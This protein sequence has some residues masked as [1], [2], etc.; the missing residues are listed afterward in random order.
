MRILPLLI[1]SKNIAQEISEIMIC[2]ITSFAFVIHVGPGY[3][4][5][6]FPFFSL[7]LFVNG[8]RKKVI[9]FFAKN[10]FI[11]RKKKWEVVVLLRV[12]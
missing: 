12:G 4:N 5:K 1:I 2:N 10:Q 6:Y 7:S 8:E 3:G 11:E 9:F